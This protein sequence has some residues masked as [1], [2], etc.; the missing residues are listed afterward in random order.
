M[1][2]KRDDLIVP[3]IVG[4]QNRNFFNQKEIVHMEDV[5]AL[6]DIGY[7]VRNIT[8]LILVILILAMV[9]F[10]YKVFYLLAR[11]G[12]EIAT[13][14]MLLA[15]VLAAVMAVDFDR[16][17]NIFHLIFFDNDLWILDPATDLLVNIVPFQ[18]FTDIAIFIGVL[19]L[20]FFTVLI[21]VSSVYL[22]RKSYRDRG[23]G[24]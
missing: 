6:F 9:F 12:R 20:L 11:C 18:F 10:K 23:A 21:I 22:G 5:K 24:L 19:A 13:G 8:F 16:A 4:G 7:K 2:G 1:Q 15:A 14:V 3:A 17:F